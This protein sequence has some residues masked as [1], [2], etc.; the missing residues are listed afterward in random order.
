[1]ALTLNTLALRVLTLNNAA[2]DTF[3]ALP[4]AMLFFILFFQ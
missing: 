4:A 3:P 1:M 2:K